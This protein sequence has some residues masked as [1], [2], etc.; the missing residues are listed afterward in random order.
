MEEL[1]KRHKIQPGDTLSGMEIPFFQSPNEIFNQGLKTHPLAIYLYLCRCSNQGSSA[2]PSYL[3]VSTSCGMSKRQ[4]IYSIKQ[5]LEMGWLTKTTSYNEK[6]KQHY[7]NSYAI[8]APP[9]AGL[10]PPSAGHA[11]PSATDAPYKEPFKKNYLKR[12][13]EKEID[14]TPIKKLTK[15]EAD[16]KNQYYLNSWQAQEEAAKARLAEMLGER[17]VLVDGK[18]SVKEA[19]LGRQLTP[20]EHLELIAEADQEL[21]RK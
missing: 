13:K 3:T 1:K 17:K 8:L 15:K 18:I 14:K 7:S 12:T 4:A 5:L 6:R 10:A 9:S 2:F 21:V 20:N 19:A 11:P 16:E